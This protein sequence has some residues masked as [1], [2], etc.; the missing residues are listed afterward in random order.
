MDS[1]DLGLTSQGNVVSENQQGNQRQDRRCPTPMYVLRLVV[2]VTSLL[3]WAL[4]RLS[5][6]LPAVRDLGHLGKEW[7]QK[8]KGERHLSVSSN[9]FHRVGTTQAGEGHTHTHHMIL[10]VGLLRESRL[11]RVRFKDHTS[12]A[13]VTR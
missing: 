9:K 1:L 10:E 6:L 3:H 12:K 13:T 5:S 7:K 4:C 11:Q 8:C 2:S